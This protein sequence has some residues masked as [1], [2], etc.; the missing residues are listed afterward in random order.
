[1]HTARSHA[2]A[3]KR[4]WTIR[5]IPQRIKKAIETLAD[6]K[7]QQ[8]LIASAGTALTGSTIRAVITSVTANLAVNKKSR[9]LSAQA[10]LELAQFSKAVP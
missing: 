8:A 1:M 5:K 6:L 9:D 7:K 4:S 10:T 3:I 2:Q